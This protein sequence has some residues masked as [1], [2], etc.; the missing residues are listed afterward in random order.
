MVFAVHL[1]HKVPHEFKPASVWITVVYWAGPSGKLTDDVLNVVPLLFTDIQ[2]PEERA[3]ITVVNCVQ[4]LFHNFV[5]LMFLRKAHVFFLIPV[6]V[7]EKR[8]VS[9]DADT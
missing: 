1:E 5:R 6:Q 4:D 7:P 3:G 2:I 8:R 9:V